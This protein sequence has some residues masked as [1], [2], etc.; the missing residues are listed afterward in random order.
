MKEFVM[1][2]SILQHLVTWL[3]KKSGPQ[4]RRRRAE[5]GMNL[6]EI[7]V[8]LVIMSLVA[9]VVGVN[10]L[11]R[12]QEA[13]KRSAS[14]QIKALTEA[15]ELYKLQFHNYPST[16]EGLQALKAPKGNASPF[17]SSIPEDPWGHEYV[18]IYPGATN[19]GGFDLMSYG[20]D[21]VQGGGD[22]ITNNENEQK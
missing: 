17:I 14:V 5:R 16:A 19:Q 2:R 6:L 15:L 12:L 11:N 3:A 22:D 9:S 20:P 10:V 18:Y 13:R 7:M 4:A 21:G 1:M 8:V